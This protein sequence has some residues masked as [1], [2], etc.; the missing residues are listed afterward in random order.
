MTDWWEENVLWV[1]AM[2]AL[3]LIVL[4]FSFLIVVAG[5]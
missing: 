5:V 4:S 2:S 1:V 3:L